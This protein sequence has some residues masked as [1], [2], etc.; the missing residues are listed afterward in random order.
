MCICRGTLV[1][2]QVVWVTDRV[3]PGW[4]DKEVSLTHYKGKKWLFQKWGCFFFP[5]A[6]NVKIIKMRNFLKNIYRYSKIRGDC[7]SRSIKAACCYYLFYSW[8]IRIHTWIEG[9]F[10]RP[11][12]YRK[13]P[14]WCQK[15]G[16]WTR[17]QNQYHTDQNASWWNSALY[18]EFFLMES[19]VRETLQHQ[20]IILLLFTID[21][22]C[23]GRSAWNKGQMQAD[24]A[25]KALWPP[26]Q[27][28]SSSY[29]NLCDAQWSHSKSATT[30]VDSLHFSIWCLSCSTICGQTGTLCKVPRM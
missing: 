9:K 7:I 13:I 16:T 24:Q 12:M 21:S 26:K 18:N 29:T 15:E 2:S 27:D 30:A 5:G 11:E 1:P 6:T 10:V 4:P 3:D 23:W 22:N 8:K 25:A 28:V 14:Y 17:T 20:G 19:L